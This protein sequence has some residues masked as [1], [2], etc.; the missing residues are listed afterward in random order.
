MQESKIISL[1]GKGHISKTCLPFTLYNIKISQ[2]TSWFFRYGK[3]IDIWRGMRWK[4]GIM[5]SIIPQPGGY[6]VALSSWSN[7]RA[8]RSPIPLYF[9]TATIVCGRDA[10]ITFLELQDRLDMLSSIELL[11]SL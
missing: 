10:K 9:N 3:G 4:N 11:E 5:Y 8:T 1:T 7:Q 2:G 6:I